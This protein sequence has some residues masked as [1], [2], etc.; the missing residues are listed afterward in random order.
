[1]TEET[2]KGGPNGTQAFTTELATFG[3]AFPDKG[4]FFALLAAWLALF[5]FLGN[6]TFGYIDT[7]SL[8]KWMY[9][10]YTTP[11]SEDSHG[12]LVPLVVAG[13]FWWKRQE[14]IPVPKATWWPGLLVIALALVLH[15]GGYLV[16]QP[17]ICIIGFLLG[18]YGLM[19]LVWGRSWLQA[20]FFPFILFL[21][22]VPIGSLAD[23][24][25]F[26]LRMLVT[27]ISVGLTHQVLG[28]AVIRDGSRIFDPQ[29]T[30]Q[31][32]VA[33]A[34]SGI[35][36]LISLLALT[37]IYGFVTFIT[38]WKRLLMVFVAL[39]L[40]LAGNVIRVTSVI[41]VAEAFGQDAGSKVHDWAGFATYGLAIAGM[42]VL[43]YFLRE[44]QGLPR[45]K[46]HPA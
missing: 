30:Y 19:G 44:D 4:L 16:Q 23:S 14:L 8:L 41:I 33:P 9:V 1:M 2:K 7:S 43:G 36:S 17:R 39:P 42:L 6:A 20:C 37:T 46:D 27:K 21:F 34:C 18:I 24:I 40:A 38:S 15:L 28:I 45:I 3:R 10:A 26:P 29:L 11:A 5:H 22:C 13:L 35:R 25:T 32:D 31:Y 12:V